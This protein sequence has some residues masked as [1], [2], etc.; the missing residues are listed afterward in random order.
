[1]TTI[2]NALRRIDRKF[3]AENNWIRGSYFG[4]A[5]K[6]PLDEI[7]VRNNKVAPDCYCLSGA[8]KLIDPE[9]KTKTKEF[10]IEQMKIRYPQLDNICEFK[11][12]NSTSFNDIKQFLRKCLNEAR[13]LRI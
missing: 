2:Y 9:E 6:E 8:R 5:N 11:S 10:M 13:R 4:D 7:Y 1:M 12:L 3:K